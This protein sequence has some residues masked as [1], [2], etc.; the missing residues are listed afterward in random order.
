VTAPLFSVVTVVLNDRAGLER[1]AAAVRGQTF[2]D[3]E[4]VVVDGKSTDGTAELAASLSPDRLVS[5]PDGGI[6]EAMNKGV[7]LAR[8]EYL[9]FMNAGDAFTTPE[10]LSVVAREALSGLVRPDVVFGGARLMFPSGRTAYRP[11]R[12]WEGYVWHGLPATHQ[13]TFYKR[14]FIAAHPYD[15]SYR[16]CGDYEIAARFFRLGAAAAYV[17]EALSD[18][19]LGGTSSRQT[20][21]LFRESL[22]IQKEVLRLGVARRLLSLG[23]RLVST[24]GVRAL[25]WRWSRP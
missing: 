11:P 18:F 8:G 12:R 13:S 15:A 21:R 5:E 2:R 16:I 9:V 17:N 4:W 3:L 14:S 20:V 22:R 19:H 23:K 6:Y 25:S 7:A 24:A 10:V 1:T